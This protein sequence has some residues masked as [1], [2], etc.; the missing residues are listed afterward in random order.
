LAAVVTVS[1]TTGYSSNPTTVAVAG[2]ILYSGSN[3][4]GLTGGEIAG[5]VIG[6]IAGVGLLS[7]LAIWFFF[8]RN[9]RQRAETQHKVAQIMAEREYQR[10]ALGAVY[11]PPVAT[12][13]PMAEIRASPRDYCI[14]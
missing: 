10:P 5:M 1:V 7:F 6:M 12:P 8:I 9:R 14:D 13:K 11:V 2:S 4:V 3:G